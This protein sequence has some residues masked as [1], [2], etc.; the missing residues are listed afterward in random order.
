MLVLLGLFF[1]V[2]HVFVLSFGM[3]MKVPELILGVIICKSLPLAPRINDRDIQRILIFACI[4]LIIAPLV[5]NLV[6]I[7]YLPEI[8]VGAVRLGVIDQIGRYSPIFAPWIM[9]AWNVFSFLTLYSLI[10]TSSE[11]FNKFFKFLMI[12]LFVSNIYAIYHAWVVNNGFGPDIP[13]PGDA[14]HGYGGWL[15]AQGFFLEPL[16]LGHFYVYCIP[17]F[18]FKDIRFEGATARIL[19]Q[20]INFWLTA[21]VFLLA[22]SAT[23]L[24]AL[25]FGYLGM[26]FLCKRYALAL[27][28]LPWLIGGVTAMSFIPVARTFFI[29]KVIFSFSEPHNVGMSLVDRLYKNESGWKDFLAHPIFGSGLGTSGFYYP[30]FG[31]TEAR[32]D[33][34]FMPM[35]LNEY[36]RLLAES[37]VFA[38]TFYGIFCFL[39]VRYLVRNRDLLSNAE[40]LAFGGGFLGTL[41]AFNFT[42]LFNVYFVWVFIAFSLSLIQERRALQPERL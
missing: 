35:P 18:F 9:W 38:V 24:I 7:L 19:F 27:K 34:G 40:L 31:P 25:I 30:E 13:W 2:S 3:N 22:F 8:Q 36:I 5:S 42:N 6:S 4:A 11:D 23:A 37:G 21:Y 16:N 17:F 32:I 1:T 10:N 20:K 33:Y 15:R 29:E 26:L 39:Y 28:S 41:V 12:S 14:R